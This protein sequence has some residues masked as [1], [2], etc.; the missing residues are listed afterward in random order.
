[1]D[2]KITIAI[3]AFEELRG[4]DI[5]KFLYYCLSRMYKFQMG[6]EYKED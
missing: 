4:E 3:K 1:M 2:N 6:E 5:H